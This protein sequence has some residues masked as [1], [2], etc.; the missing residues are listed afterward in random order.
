VL[1]G[2]KLALGGKLE[3][4]PRK[5]PRRL[6]QETGVSKTTRRT[7]TELLKLKGSSS[8]LAHKKRARFRIAVQRFI[9]AILKRNCNVY[10]LLVCR[11]LPSCRDDRL[12][13]F[14]FCGRKTITRRRSRCRRG[15]SRQIC[16]RIT[17]LM[18][19][20]VAD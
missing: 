5:S 20:L 15:S 12:S 7:A 13:L 10:R 4:F 1:T 9:E 17:L 8:Q 18:K 3:Y 14:L 11:V 19:F 16:S 6:A 2:K